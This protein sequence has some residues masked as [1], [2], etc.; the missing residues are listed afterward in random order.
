MH[1]VFAE[2]AL[3]FECVVI[4]IAVATVA[5]LH[6]LNLQV[7]VSTSQKHTPSSPDALHAISV[8]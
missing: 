3:H 5:S 8:K 1:G 7:V 2:K 4:S 6:S